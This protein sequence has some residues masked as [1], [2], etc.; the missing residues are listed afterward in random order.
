MATALTPEDINEKISSK[1]YIQDYK[2]KPVIDGVSIVTLKNMSGEDSDFSELLRINP[3]GEAELFPGF[4]VAQINRSTQIPGSVKAW[5]IHFAQD[6]LWYVAD[7]SRLMTGL[8]DVRK[9]SPTYGATMRIPMGGSSHRM[10]YI[11][12]G[13]AHGAANFSS[14]VATIMYFMNGQFNVNNP[15]ERRIPWDTLGKEFWEPQRD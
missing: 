1:I 9:N 10:V 7:E 14:N 2:S 15:D 12:R 13:V 11:P 3:Q 4:H 5:H 6:E 8:W